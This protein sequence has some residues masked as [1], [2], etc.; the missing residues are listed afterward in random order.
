MTR[1]SSAR[2]WNTA[3]LRL[4]GAQREPLGDRV[5]ARG[6]GIRHPTSTGAAGNPPHRSREIRRASV[7]IAGE[8]RLHQAGAKHRVG[9]RETLVL[10]EREA[11]HRDDRGHD[12]AALL[13]EVA[14]GDRDDAAQVAAAAE[15]LHRERRVVD[16]QRRSRPRAAAEHRRRP[17]RS[18][19]RA[20]RRR[21]RPRGARGSARRRCRRARPTCR[22]GARARRGSRRDRRAGGRPARSRAVRRAPSCA[23]RR[24]A[25][26]SP[27]RWRAPRR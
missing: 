14:G 26:R 19:R 12:P 16:P 6:R 20:S 5:R 22:A 7:G 17:R 1:A 2:P 8:E 18:A 23:A 10:L 25:R 11:R 9:A 27:R 13:V 21:A 24:P 3:A 15:R 4:G